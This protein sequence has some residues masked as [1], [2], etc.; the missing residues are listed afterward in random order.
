MPHNSLRRLGF[1]LV[2]A[3]AAA[4]CAPFLHASETSRVPGPQPDGSV[5]LPNQW[6]LRPVG[7]QLTVGDFPVNIAMHPAGSHAVVLH[8]GYGQHELVVLDVGSL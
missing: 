1:S 3:L 8:C 7:R 6:T 5:V 2:V 4:A